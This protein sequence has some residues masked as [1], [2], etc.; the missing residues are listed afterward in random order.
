[1]KRDMDLVRKILL[2]L[3]EKEDFVEPT[4]PDI[5]GYTENQIFYHIKLMAEAN[6]IEAQDWSSFD[7]P[8]WVASRLTTWG[9]DFLD[10]ARNDTI[11]KKAKDVVLSTGSSLTIDAL[12]Y[13]LTEIVKNAIKANAS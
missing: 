1:M 3:E 2:S 11:W 7:G 8:Q 6:L 5:E 12:K 4:I 10:S 13:A 9:H